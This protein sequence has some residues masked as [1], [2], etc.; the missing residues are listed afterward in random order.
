MKLTSLTTRVG[1]VEITVSS[2]AR[3][4]Q[5][6]DTRVAPQLGVQLIAA[7]I[8]REHPL[9]AAR[10]Q[11]LGEAACRRADVERQ[12]P[13]HDDRP[14][15]QRVDELQRPTP[16]PRMSRLGDDLGVLVDRIGRLGDHLAIDRDEAS[17]DGRAGL[18][19]AV[20]DAPLD[21][22][23]IDTLAGHAASSKVQTAV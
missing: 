5:V 17:L 22:Q 20:D 14:Q 21:E 18:G 6:D 15:V 7:N 2:S 13:L 10:Q 23:Q 3:A 12:A 11:D 4:R 9:G 1:A 16:D 19:A 8:D